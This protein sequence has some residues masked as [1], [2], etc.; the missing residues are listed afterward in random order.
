MVLFVG[1]P[2][3]CSHVL[4]VIDTKY[5]RSQQKINWPLKARS[6]GHATHFL[7]FTPAPPPHISVVRVCVC[8]RQ[9]ECD[10]GWR[11]ISSL[12]CKWTCWTKQWTI[13]IPGHLEAKILKNHVISVAGMK[14]PRWPLIL[15][16]TICIIFL[17]PLDSLDSLSLK[18]EF[19]YWNHGH[20]APSIW[21]IDK[22]IQLCIKLM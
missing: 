11:D 4:Q 5:V 16:H 22:L 10:N 18:C 12:V 20:W 14:N 6:Q 19:S 2:T 13:M 3:K 17:P 9:C 15:C 7:K 21:D 1:R 8:V